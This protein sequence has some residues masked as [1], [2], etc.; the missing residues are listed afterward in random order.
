MNS[1]LHYWVVKAK[2]KDGRWVNWAGVSAATKEEARA[3]AQEQVGFPIRI[4][5]GSPAQDRK[6]IR[7]AK[8]A[9]FPV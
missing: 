7:Q 1:E 6:F 9:G 3:K 2:N 8:D 4:V 5:K